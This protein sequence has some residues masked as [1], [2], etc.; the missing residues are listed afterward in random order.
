MTG[1]VVP[2]HQA[3]CVASEDATLVYRDL[4][5]FTITIQLRSVGWSVDFRPANPDEQGGGPHYVIDPV[6]GTI[7][8]KKYYQ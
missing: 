4:S 2:A 8:S 6:D 7:K 1:N 5:D 3:L